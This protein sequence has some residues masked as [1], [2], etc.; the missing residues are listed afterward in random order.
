MCGIAGFSLLDDSREGLGATVSKMGAA[1]VHRGPDGYGEIIDES[2]G[3]AACC[4]RLSIVGGDSGRQPI[5]NEDGSIAVVAN[6]EIYNWRAL[7]QDLL[8]R[9]HVF[10][11]QSD[12]EVIV[13]LYE[14]LGDQ[15]FERLEG[16]FG[17]AVLDRRRRRLVLARDRCG[18]KPLYCARAGSGLLFASEIK[19]LFSSG[20]VAPEPASSAIA[21]YLAIGYTPSP[22][23]CFAGVEKLP[24]GECWTFDAAGLRRRVYWR[25]RFENPETTTSSVTA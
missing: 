11:T 14:E 16:M 25:L 4:R 6:G 24:A 17:V 21:T 18:M 7:V 19:A 8:S 10:Q 15:C 13:H 1:L 9:G 22:A 12:V 20:R 5:W 2:W 3:A 23:T